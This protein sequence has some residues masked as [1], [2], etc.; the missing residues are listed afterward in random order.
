MVKMLLTRETASQEKECRLLER[1]RDLQIWNKVANISMQEDGT[2]SSKKD[3]ID[4]EMIFRQLNVLKQ[5]GYWEHLPR[6]EDHQESTPDLYNREETINGEVQAF[7]H[8]DENKENSRRNYHPNRNVQYSNSGEILTNINDDNGEVGDEDENEDEDEQG[9]DEY[10]GERE[11]DIGGTSVFVGS[12]FINGFGGAE[13][14]GFYVDEITGDGW[15]CSK[16]RQGKK[17]NS[18]NDDEDIGE[19]EHHSKLLL[20]LPSKVALLGR[21]GMHVQGVNLLKRRDNGVVEP[22][23]QY[24]VVDDIPVTLSARNGTY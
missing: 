21:L 16:F 17:K 3:S 2:S 12:A 6:E 13:P 8:E 5:G 23:D 24:C 10:G 20:R 9:G 11:M 7:V 15:I 14:V 22:F 4:S 1:Y 18:F 19:R